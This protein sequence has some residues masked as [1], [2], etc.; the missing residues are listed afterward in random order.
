MLG[1][2][3]NNRI[4]AVAISICGLAQWMANF[5]VTW[6]FPILTGRHGIGVGQTY[7]LYTL[8]AFVSIFFV[9]KFIRE[10]NG[11]QLEEM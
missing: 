3:F 8:F 6:S 2:M 11:K 9:S 7:L 1:E 5:L 4:R 10:T